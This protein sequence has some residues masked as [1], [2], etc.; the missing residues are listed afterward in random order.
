MSETFEPLTAIEEAILYPS[1]LRPYTAT[2]GP[3]LN[4]STEIPYSS[5]RYTRS[6]LQKVFPLP[7]DYK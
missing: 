2:E 6:G 4:V 3:A 5:L 7:T 1:V